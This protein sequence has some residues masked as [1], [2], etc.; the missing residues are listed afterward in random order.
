MSTG[1]THFIIVAAGKGS[2]FGASLPKQFCLLGGRPV[3]MTTID[4]ARTTLPDAEILLVLSPE[5]VDY[6]ENLC[7]KYGFVSPKIVSGGDTRWQSVKNALDSLP[8]TDGVVMIHDGA[9]PLISGE[10]MAGL[11]QAMESGAQGALPVV[12]P[13][14]SMRIIDADGSSHALDRSKLRAVQTPQAFRSRLLKAAYETGFSPE[15]TD[16]ASVMEKA[17]FTDLRLVDGDPATMKITLPAD[18][19]IV[20]L[21]MEN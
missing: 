14:D 16:D 3:L 9:R 2:R 8:A 11:T 1:K 13:A 18:L 20:A 19:K 10:V 5:F 6:W 21:F 7:G 15:L 17:G 4:R 12:R